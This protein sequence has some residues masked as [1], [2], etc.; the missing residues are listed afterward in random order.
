MLRELYFGKVIP[1]ERKNRKCVEQ[2]EVVRKIEEEERYF[3]D[4]LSQ[5][6]RERF[7]A[8]IDLCSDLAMSEECELFSYSFTM[9]A[10]LMM[11]MLD[12]AAH[13]EVNQ[14]Q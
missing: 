9:G 5:E 1:W 13:M 12:E 2:L 6:D 10:F 7:K 8:L 11:D 4:I 3:R 14:P